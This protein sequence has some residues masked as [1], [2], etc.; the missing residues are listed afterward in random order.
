MTPQERMK[1]KLKSLGIPAREISVYGSQIVVTCLSRD[2][3]EKWSMVLARF[4]KV[5][6]TALPSTDYMMSD[7]HL[8]NM[9]RTIDVWRTYAIVG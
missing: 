2:A 5:T 4:A 1:E 3:A 7:K 9:R 6:R 8:P